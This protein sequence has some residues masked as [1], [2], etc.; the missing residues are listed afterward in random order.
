MSDLSNHVS[1]TITRDNVGVARQG[2]GTPMILTANASWVERTRTYNTITDVAADFPSTTGPEYLA[3]AAMLNQNPHPKSI[4]I[5][6]LANKP[7]LVYEI[8]V[9]T[10]RNSFAYSV[11]VKGDGVTA[12]TATYT[13][14]ASATNDEIVAG[15]VTAINAVAANNYTAAATGGVGVQVVTITADAVANWFSIEIADPTA[16]ESKMTHVDAGIAADLTAILLADSA[17]YGF[18]N[19]YN[20]NA[21]AL[22]AAAWAQTN[23][24]L[25]MCDTSETETITTAAGNS[26]TADDIATLD[27][28]YS[29]VFYHPAPDQMA[30]AAL[31]G[32]CLPLVPGSETWK[33][34]KLTGVVAVPMTATQR[35]NLVSRNANSYEE[36]AGIG[37]TFNGTVPSGEFIDVI[38]GLDALEDDIKKS[39]FQVLVDNDKVP[40][41]DAG[42]NMV[43]SPVRGALRRWV[44]NGLLADD[45]KPAVTSPLVADVSSTD[46]G[47]RYLP[48]IAFSAELAGAVHSTSI[49]GKVSV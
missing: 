22:A 48:D 37:M 44:Q 31:L 18:V 17:W 13:S 29:P 16:L 28:T 20:S 3:A 42:V 7:T 27:Y 45:P 19:S 34:K 47:N 32:R 36:V 4:K 12:T 30:G 6:R 10:V 23:R 43:E 26:E 9:S 35:A 38:R 33:F 5:G 39:V 2:F 46:R 14:D 41:T 1:I 21:V 40:F 15:L 25:F 49:T 11:N 8:Q 24:R